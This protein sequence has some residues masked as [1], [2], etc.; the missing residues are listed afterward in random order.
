MAILLTKTD[1]SAVASPRCDR[2]ANAFHAIT[3]I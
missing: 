2:G 3:V 1:S